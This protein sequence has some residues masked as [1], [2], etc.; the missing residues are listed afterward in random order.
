MTSIETLYDRFVQSTGVSTD[1]RRIPEGA[2]F[3]ALKGPRFNAN[4]FAD[5]ALRLGARFA[6]VDDPAHANDDRILLVE[7]GLRALQ[8]LARHHRRRFESP[9]LAITGSNGKTTT[10]ELIHAVMA[11]DRPTLATQG[12]LNNHIGVPLTLLQLQPSHRFAIIEM[13]ANKPGDIAELA[14]IAEPT[15]GLITNV[16]KAHLEGF[17]DFEGVLRTKSE[18]YD[19]LQAHSGSAFVNGDD[20]TLRSRASMLSTDCY[21]FGSSDDAA[22]KGRDRSSSPFLAFE[23]IGRHGE[24]I[25]VSTKLIGRYNLPNALAAVAVGQA[26]GVDD[27]SIAGALAGYTP[28]NNRSQYLE[29]G[30][31]QVIADAYNANPSSMEAALRNF[32]A[33]PSSRPKLAILGD[34]LELGTESNPEHERIA[35]LASELGLEVWFVGPQFNQIGCGGLHFDSSDA[36]ASFLEGSPITGRLVMLKGSRGIGLERLLPHL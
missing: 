18:L 1:T 15:H 3:I 5:E 13:G 23:F 2:M 7:D 26:F 17:G 34:M 16:G 25:P 11:A 8:E 31:N 29:T 36:A 20:L 12:N 14:A 21:I 27:R 32:A 9:V 24:W 19:Y 30:S 10:K 33:M 22:T 28:S 6:V 4:A 35:G